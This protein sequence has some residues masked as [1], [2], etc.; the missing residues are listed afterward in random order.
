MNKK[1]L[2]IFILTAF[3]VACGGGHV[4]A[5]PPVPPT[6]T[7]SVQPITIPQQADPELVTIITSLDNISRSTISKCVSDNP[8]LDP[9]KLVLDSSTLTLDVATQAYKTYKFAINNT[10]NN[11]A[12][13]TGYVTISKSPDGITYLL[14]NVDCK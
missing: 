4:T 7:N 1:R 12:T 13:L 8:S 14:Y 3:L 6:T 5:I 10:V 11:T 9:S 2:A